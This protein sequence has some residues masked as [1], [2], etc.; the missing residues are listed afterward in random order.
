[1]KF[2]ESLALI[3]VP[4]AEPL[5]G[6]WRKKYDASAQRGVPAHIT[7]IYPFQSPDKLD[8]G[9]TDQL[10]SLF[11]NANPFSFELT[12]IATFPAVIFLDPSPREPFIELIQKLVELYP[13]TPPCAGQYSTINPHLTL[14]VLPESADFQN[15]L[16]TIAQDLTPQLPALAQ[17]T[18]VW[19]MVKD[20]SHLWRLRSKFKLGK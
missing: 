12:K 15:I 4:A 9:V 20:E 6:K 19:L 2:I 14:A 7:L 1:M 10:K 18:E 8:G 3:P 13:D 11:E 17:A 16:K 5:V